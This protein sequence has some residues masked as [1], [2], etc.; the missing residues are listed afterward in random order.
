MGNRSWG[1]GCAG[2]GTIAT[3]LLLGRFAPGAGVGLPG[4]LMEVEVPPPTIFIGVPVDALIRVSVTRAPRSG[5]LLPARKTV[6]SIRPVGD[7]GAP[8]G[9]GVCPG[10][11]RMD[12]AMAIA[13]AMSFNETSRIQT[14]ELSSAYTTDG[15]SVARIS[16]VSKVRAVLHV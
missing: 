16:R 14:S 11:V 8:G 6:H 4:E 9:A 2:A 15:V 13:L 5:S 3:P 12:K 10:K 1:C 7:K